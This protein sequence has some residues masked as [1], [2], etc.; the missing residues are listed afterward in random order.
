MENQL[1][2]KGQLKAHP[3]SEIL[4]L[5][6]AGIWGPIKV[7]AGKRTQS[8]IEAELKKTHIHAT[9]HI[10]VENHVQGKVYQNL[11]SPYEK[12]IIRIKGGQQ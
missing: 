6:G 11:H 8:A 10:H 2:I 7:Y 1:N 9:A 4:I 3:E 5:T 12:K